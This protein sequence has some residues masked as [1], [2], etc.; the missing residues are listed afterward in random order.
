M[1]LYFPPLV[2][3]FFILVGTIM[4]ISSHSI[5][6]MWF[7]MEVNLMAFMPMITNLENNKKSSEAS[8]KYFIIQSI[9]STFFL[10]FC[11]LFY[12]TQTSSFMSSNLMSIITLT[13]GLKMGL[14][15]LHFWF[16]EVLEGLN[17]S[18]TLIML[19]WQKVAPLFILS[20][21][22]QPSVLIMLIFFSSFMGA[23]SGLNQTSL[24]KILAFSSISHLSWISALIMVKSELWINYLIIYSFTSFIVC[25]SFWYY[26]LNYFSQ[27]L[28]VKDLMKKVIVF[29]NILSLAGLPP[30]LGFLPK[31]MTIN[32]LLYNFS[33]L[34]I[35]ILSS[36]IT[37]YFYSRLCFSTF[38]L[39]IQENKGNFKEEDTKSF[40]FLSGFTISSLV[41]FF[42]LFIIFK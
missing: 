32:L 41:G 7:G 17:W 11:F 24:R 16:P 22:F 28:W 39:S 20:I 29:I 8:I 42:P 2:Y 26:S 40:I 23:I 10:L 27:L 36:L 35:L 12:E 9:A 34:I 3:I 21:L 18:N 1:S 37:L 25:L 31:L 19:T 38:T 13:L 5:F 6:G 14:S 15:P 33:L 4:T 30:L